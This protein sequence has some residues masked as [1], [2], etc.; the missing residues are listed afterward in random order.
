MDSVW[1]LL[2]PSD[3]HGCG[4]GAGVGLR[5]GAVGAGVGAGAGAAHVWPACGMLQPAVHQ[6][7][8]VQP[9][10]QPVPAL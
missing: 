2:V 7:P 10:D 5:V 3:S 4:V 9:H 1:H 8:D 6:L